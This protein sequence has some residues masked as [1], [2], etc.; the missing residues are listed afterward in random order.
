MT[1]RAYKQKFLPVEMTAGSALENLK[2]EA[3][4]SSFRPEENVVGETKF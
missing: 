4:L 1:G 3:I 2:S